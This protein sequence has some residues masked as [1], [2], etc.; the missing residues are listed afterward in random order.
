MY[1]TITTAVALIGFAGSVCSIAA[2]AEY[3]VDKYRQRKRR[4]KMME[5]EEG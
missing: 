3:R 4:K 2:Y 5:K 1:E